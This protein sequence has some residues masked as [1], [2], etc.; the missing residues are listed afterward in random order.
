MT[1]TKNGQ[2]DHLLCV[3]PLT[4]KN[5]AFQDSPLVPCRGEERLKSD[6]RQLQFLQR[7]SHIISVEQETHKSQKTQGC[8]TFR[9]WQR[10]MFLTFL[11]KHHIQ[12]F[13]DVKN[14]N[15]SGFLWKHVRRTKT[16]TDRRLPHLSGHLGVTS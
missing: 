12:E 4:E 9:K 8:S 13:L 7:C 2:F 11:C 5:R 3:F 1:Q 6:R 15:V 16:E 14:V 10:Q